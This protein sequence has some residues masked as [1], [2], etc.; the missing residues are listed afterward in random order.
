MVMK[1][2][3]VFVGI[4]IIVLIILFFIIKSDKALSD[5]EI[6]EIIMEATDDEIIAVY[7][8][9]ECYM[10]DKEYEKIYIVV[11]KLKEKFVHGMMGEFE[12][13]YYFLDKDGNIFIEN[14]NPDETIG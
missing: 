6:K 14:Y 5:E 11:T 12:Y 10:P 2:I 7:Y 9:D 3:G 4:L 1:K 8:Y 13:K